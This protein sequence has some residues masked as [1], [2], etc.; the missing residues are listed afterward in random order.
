M[1]IS[2]DNSRLRLAKW[3]YSVPVNIVVAYYDPS[4]EQNVL[5]ADDNKI[6]GTVSFDKKQFYSDDVITVTAAPNPG[7]ALKEIIVTDTAS[8]TSTDITETKQFTSGEA[9]VE[10]IVHF[11]KLADNT[12]KAGGKTAKV[13]YKKL[14]KKKQTV[15]CAKMMTISGAQGKLTYKIVSVNKKKSSFKI[16]SGNGNVTV[17]KKLKKGTYKL[18]VSVTAAGNDKYKPVTQTVTFRIKVK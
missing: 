18:K 11:Q 12:L 10:I 3:H 9:G 17:K 14:R 1:I 15:K 16:N 4:G 6:S 5:T 13:K 2:S 7:F 8:G